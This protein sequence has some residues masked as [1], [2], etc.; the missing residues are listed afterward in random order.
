[1]LTKI[2]K[3]CFFPFGIASVIC[4]ITACLLL[5]SGIKEEKNVKLF[6]LSSTTLFISTVACS[7]KIKSEI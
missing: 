5:T 1:M 6:L 7:V 2:A 4:C 3:F